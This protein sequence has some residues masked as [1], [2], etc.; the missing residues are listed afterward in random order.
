[1]QKI[2]QLSGKRKNKMSVME[3]NRRRCPNV[4]CDTH[5]HGMGYICND[6]QQEFRGFLLERGL[7]PDEISVHDIEEQ[8]AVFMNTEKGSENAYTVSN[9]DDYF[10]EHSR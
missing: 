10:R 8:I 6:C 5:I 7:N 4:M 3:C 1:M 9:I 2:I